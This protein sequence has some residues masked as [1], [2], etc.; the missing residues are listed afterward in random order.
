MGLYPPKISSVFLRI[1]ALI[2][3][4]LTRSNIFSL[5]PSCPSNLPFSSSQ[6]CCPCRLCQP[7]GV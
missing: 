6:V 3:A 7:A 1:Q 2:S 5:S 4:K